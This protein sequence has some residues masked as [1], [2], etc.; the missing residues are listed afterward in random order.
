[1]KI[2][3]CFACHRTSDTSPSFFIQFDNGSYI[4]NVP[5]GTQRVFMDH[6]WKVSKIKAAFMTSLDENSTGGFLGMIF[7]M[8]SSENFVV[9]KLIGPKGLKEQ[10]LCDFAYKDTPEYLPEISDFYSDENLTVKTIE[11]TETIAFD[12]QLRS[13]PGKFLLI[14]LKN[15][16]SLLV[17]FSEN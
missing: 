3:I 6:R 11:L 7:T 17:L 15:L 16:V 9:P 1:M 14:K 10:L 12:I 2:E 5:D 13:Y 4:F 8:L